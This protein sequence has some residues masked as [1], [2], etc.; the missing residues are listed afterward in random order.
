M[1]RSGAGKSSL[2]NLILR[3]YEAE[4]GAISIDDQSI[5]DVTQ[6][7]LRRNIGMVTQD[8]SLLHRSIRDNINYGKPSASDTEIIAAAKQAEAWD[9]IPNLQDTEGRSGLEA[10]VGERG[11]KLSGGQRQRISIARAII[12]NAPILILDEAT[13]ALDSEVEFTIQDTLYL[14]LIHI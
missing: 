12:K 13:S 5:K 3:F 7:S 14:S 9:F 8:S 11:V 10:H 4:K 1:G 2:V 6:N